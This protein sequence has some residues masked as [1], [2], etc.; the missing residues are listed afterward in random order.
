MQCFGPDEGIIST[1]LFAAM[2]A[3][4]DSAHLQNRGM[5]QKCFFMCCSTFARTYLRAG[6]VSFVVVLVANGSNFFD[7][8]LME[9]AEYANY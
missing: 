9:K 5:Q 2:G 1:D 8:Q 6:D 4:F 7:N 3:L